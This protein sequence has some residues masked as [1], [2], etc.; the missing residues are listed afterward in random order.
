MLSGWPCSVREHGW[1]DRARRFWTP[2][3][4]ALSCM[5]ATEPSQARW[6]MTEPLDVQLSKKVFLDFARPV[7]E[8]FHAGPAYPALTQRK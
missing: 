7:R 8:R 6:A 1:K 4:H 2:P 3:F 5:P